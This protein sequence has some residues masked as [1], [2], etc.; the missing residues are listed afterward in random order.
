MPIARDS[1]RALRSCPSGTI[2]RHARIDVAIGH[3]S[4]PTAR[5][6]PG[7]LQFLERRCHRTVSLVTVCTVA[8]A[9]LKSIMRL[10]FVAV[11]LSICFAAHHAQRADALGPPADPTIADASA[12]PSVVQETAP[13]PQTTTAAA[14]TVAPIAA[15]IPAPVAPVVAPA[16]RAVP[17]IIAAVLARV[18][19][20]LAPAIAAFVARIPPVAAPVVAAVLDRVAQVVP[21]VAPIVAPIPAPV[22]A[23]VAPVAAPITAPVPAPVEQVAAPVVAPVAPVASPVVPA[24]VSRATGDT[25]PIV[26]RPPV[27]SKASVPP[28]TVAR[29]SV[30]T[31]ASA[32]RLSVVETTLR[33]AIV[34]TP[35]AAADPHLARPV[36]HG[37]PSPHLPTMLLL[38]ASA[39]ALSPHD[40]PSASGGGVTHPGSFAI[41]AVLLAVA[42]AAGLLAERLRH[43]RAVRR[44]WSSG[45]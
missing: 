42:A 25:S 19:P 23:P 34:S 27:S 43:A 28:A 41:L 33:S 30:S 6:R 35:V 36:R 2:R 12:T 8:G 31:A 17:P 38:P 40:V 11:A 44:Q 37:S 13:S 39:Q 45:P 10:L 15:P 32:S 21:A 14:D 24:Q 20:V 5:P 1:R 4:A 9:R 3:Y 29:T 22:P 18:A 26:R 7:L 16:A